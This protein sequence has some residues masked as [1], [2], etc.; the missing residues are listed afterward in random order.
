MHPFQF[1][2]HDQ[3]HEASYVISGTE[4]HGF[5]WCFLEEDDLVRS[6][7]HS[8]IF[9]YS[10]GTLMAA[11]TYDPEHEVLVEAI[12]MAILPLYQQREALRNPQP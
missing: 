5:F 10:N 6:F 9:S 1:Y 11:K 3:W 7:G 4:A 8:M 2:Y 12:R